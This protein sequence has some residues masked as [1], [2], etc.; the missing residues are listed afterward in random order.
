MVNKVLFVLVASSEHARRQVS[1][2]VISKINMLRISLIIVIV[3]SFNSCCLF[4]GKGPVYQW[5]K[6]KSKYNHF[7]KHQNSPSELT[8]QLTTDK[9]EYF[10]G[11]PK[12][13]NL[14]IKN[15]SKFD[16]ILIDLPK[17]YKISL[18]DSNGII[19][20]CMWYEQVNSTML[21]QDKCGRRIIKVYP[22]NII[23]APNDSILFSDSTFLNY[24]G[25]PC[26]REIEWKNEDMGGLD[27]SRKVGILP[28]CL[29]EGNYYINLEYEHYMFDKEEIPI[30][31]KIN[32]AGTGFEILP[33]SEK[34][35]DDY[36]QFLEF[37]SYLFKDQPKENVWIMRSKEFKRKNPENLY[38]KNLTRFINYYSKKQSNL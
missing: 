10:I 13:L 12:H 5:S 19:K 14:I 30:K 18:S 6:D 21:I 29:S 37:C 23:L 8:F 11:E 7:L 25:E 17:F 16:S 2:S 38:N 26:G 33:F 24:F 20:K 4:V 3:V 31:K 9:K 15:N 35:E 32:I 1:I 34:A 27:L 28:C 22:P 36:Y